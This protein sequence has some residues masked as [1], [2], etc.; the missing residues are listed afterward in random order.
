MKIL[1]YSE[2]WLFKEGFISLF[3]NEPDFDVVGESSDEAE[4]LNLANKNK[5]DVILVDID[6]QENP[7]YDI[8]Q[9]ISNNFPNIA[10]IVF[11]SIDSDEV[12]LNVISYGAIGF[13][14]KIITKTK[15]IASLKAV[16]RGEAVIKRKMVTK[17]ISEFSR[18][19]KNNSFN[20]NKEIAKLTYREYEI[21]KCLENRATN[22]EIAKKLFISENTVRVH[23]HNILKK[24]NA[25][26]RREAANL[27]DRYSRMEWEEI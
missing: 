3:Q 22:R 9:K 27:A 17:I 23:V 15:L 20:K 26:N 14:P 19:T 13:L 10:I 1:I 24:L 18:I 12:L 8:V 5:P 11:S 7:N 21:L 6:Y 4:L 2:Y 25:Q 16:Q